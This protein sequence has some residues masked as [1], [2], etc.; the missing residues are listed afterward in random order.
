MKALR[1]HQ[2]RV[3]GIRNLDRFTLTPAS[4]LTVIAGE[5]GRGKT[6]LLEA[7]YLAATSRSFRTSSLDEVIQRGRQEAFTSIRVSEGDDLPRD[8]IVAFAGNRR[9]VKI[10]GK[11]PPSLAAFAVQSPMVCFHAGELELSSGPASPR[12]TLLDR[13]ALFFDPSVGD[14][15]QR[16]QVALRERQRAL[17]ARG[18][19]AR[20]LDAFEELAAFHGAA[21]TRGRARAVAE[22]GPDAHAAFVRIATPG[23]TLR[24]SYQPGGAADPAEARAELLARREKDRL[25]GLATFGPHRDELLLELDDAP[26]RSVASQGQHRAIT[27][28]LKLAEVAAISRARNLHAVL[29]LD[30]LSS[31]LDAARTDALLRTLADSPCQ[32]LITTTRPELFQAPFVAREDRLDVV[33]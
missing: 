15:R 1:L 12:R 29:L 5:N 28:A 9:S 11:R 6:T 26:A 27:L 13:I 21:L 33:L 7:A 24:V 19:Q 20:D 8:Q 25:R 10:D 17:E 14:H 4:R 32:M 23:R 3:A 31:E 2:L 30:D 16:A 18:T 22:L